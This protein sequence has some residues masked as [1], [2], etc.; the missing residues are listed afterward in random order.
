[1]NTGTFLNVVYALFSGVV[2]G[3]MATL[4]IGPTG[5][6]SAKRHLRH[7]IKAGLFVGFGSNLADITYLYLSGLGLA[8]FANRSANW[9]AVFWLICGLV[10]CFVGVQAVFRKTGIFNF[11]PG[12]KEPTSV[13][14]CLLV[15]FFLTL[16]NPTT[17]VIWLGIS[18][19]VLHIWK[20]Q[21]LYYYIVIIGIIMGIVVNFPLQN[22]IIYKG[23]H[24]MRAGKHTFLKI[25]LGL[26]LIVIG[27]MFAYR[28]INYFL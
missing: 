24:L 28:G 8:I 12:E 21:G 1:M 2:T 16:V 18:S 26:G 20:S 3:V 4:P 9:D 25:L 7:G 10:L 19:S 11:E 6:E 23:L 13:I 22:V 27:S 5:I 17:P 14:K 15:G